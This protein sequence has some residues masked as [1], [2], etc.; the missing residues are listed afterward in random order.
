M[1]KNKLS[2]ETVTFLRRISIAL[3]ILL[4][5]GAVS[6]DI[7]GF[8]TG[9]GFS[10][11]QIA[12]L[13]VGIAFIS[14]GFLGRKIPFI[15]KNTGVILLNILVAVLIIEMVSIV[16]VKIIDNERFVTRQI[17]LQIGH[18]DEA[19]QPMT[20]G[21]YTPF[22]VWRTDPLLN[23]D[24]ITVSEAGYRN[25]IGNPLD[26]D[27]AVVMIFGGSTIWGS[28]VS[29]S[30]TIPS[31]LQQILNESASEA[32][33]VLNKGQCGYSSTQEV[34]ELMLQLRDGNIPDLVVYC[35]GFNDIWGAYEQGR[36][37]SHHGVKE[38]TARLDATAVPPVVK[39][40]AVNLLR[41]TNS[42]LLVTSLID[43]F[44]EEEPTPALETYRTMGVCPDSLARDLV[45]VYLGN[46]RLV[47]ALAAEYDF[48]AIFV[49]QPSLWF[50]NKQTTEY[51]QGVLTGISGS[52]PAGKDPD[53]KELFEASYDLL[54]E[55]TELLG[56]F[57]SYTGIFDQIEET[58][59][60]DYC[61]VHIYGWANL[62][63]A[64]SLASDIRAMAP[65]L[66]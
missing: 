55:E 4:I 39:T 24:S 7:S 38:L 33:L 29:D 3:G 58:V 59:Y 1:D 37:G 2:E 31:H 42:W 40:L 12:F 13:L 27:A 35:D 18:L 8:S 57:V 51:E 44:A 45:D 21:V 22:V 49:L 10:K 17:K 46:I 48:K 43:K 66:F 5:L 47:E 52:F 16:L 60:T 26:T 34:I 54:S 32:V 14:M 62:I 9:A 50:C 19:E 25:T 53:F 65:D 63:I 11:N 28:G 61:G 64:E 36:A 56:D 41:Q 20:S 30:N 15:Y 23:N 6:A